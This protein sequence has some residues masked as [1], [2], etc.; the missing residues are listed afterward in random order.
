M[1]ADDSFGTIDFACICQ[2]DANRREFVQRIA[3]VANVDSYRI[4]IKT[5]GQVIKAAFSKRR[6]TLKNAL[7]GSNLF[8]DS[9]HIIEILETVDID[10]TRRAETLSIDEYVKLSNTVAG[11]QI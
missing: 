6:K 4:R 3:D 5:N 9:Q 10:P 1:I 2:F 7:T 11:Q 8:K